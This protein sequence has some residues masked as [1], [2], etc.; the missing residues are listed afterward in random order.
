MTDRYL[1]STGPPSPSWQWDESAHVL[2]PCCPACGKRLTM[3]GSRLTCLLMGYSHFHEP[4]EQVVA[5]A[6]GRLA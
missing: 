6:L 3:S 1:A 5:Q 4:A 2:R